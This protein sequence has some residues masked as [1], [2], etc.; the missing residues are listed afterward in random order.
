[1][2]RFGVFSGAG[3][4][5]LADQGGVIGWAIAGWFKLLLTY[6]CG[7]GSPVHDFLL[8]EDIL[9]LLV[10]EFSRNSGFRG[11]VFSYGEDTANAISV[12]TPTRCV[13]GDPLHL[14][15]IR[16]SA[17]ARKGD[18]ALYRTDNRKAPQQLDWLPK[19]GLQIGF[20]KIFNC[21]CETEAE[22]GSRISQG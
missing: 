9:T 20:T 3:Q 6:L 17:K 1:M 22:L 21:T 12:C 5:S 16:H 13:Q 2:N 7:R 14:T 11:C 19:I 15:S 4:F 18:V 8:V 10:Q